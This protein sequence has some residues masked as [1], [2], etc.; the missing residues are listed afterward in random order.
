MDISK[1]IFVALQESGLLKHYNQL[2]E[3]LV[4]E[5]LSKFK[6]VLDE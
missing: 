4:S 6:V 2:D 3:T 5:V 1:K